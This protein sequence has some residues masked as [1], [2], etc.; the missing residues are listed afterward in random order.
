MCDF[1]CVVGLFSVFVGYVSV[2]FGCAFCVGELIFF[3]E[4]LCFVCCIS[5]LASCVCWVF[6]LCAVAS[7][8]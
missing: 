5:E 1:W 3:C 8:L 4:L 2:N 7:L 6:L